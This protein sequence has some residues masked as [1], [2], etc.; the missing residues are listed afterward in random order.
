LKAFLQPFEPFQLDPTM[1]HG[2][3]PRCPDWTECEAGSVSVESEYWKSSLRFHR[4]RARPYLL[5]VS[6]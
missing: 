2:A 5:D 1:E 3:A 6:L 4:C